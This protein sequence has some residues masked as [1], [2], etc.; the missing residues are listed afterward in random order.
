MAKFTFMGIMA[1][2]LFL[3]LV[4]GSVWSV[5]QTLPGFI[6]PPEAQFVMP[7]YPMPSDMQSQLVSPFYMGEAL[8]S[9]PNSFESLYTRYNLPMGTT[10]QL[11]QPLSYES[12][13]PSQY[14]QG[15]IST[16][17]ESYSQYFDM[18]GRD[19]Y[20]V[21][22]SD[23]RGQTDLGG[24]RYSFAR[25]TRLYQATPVQSEQQQEKTEAGVCTDCVKEKKKSS[26]LR[27]LQLQSVK[28][29]ILSSGEVP[30]NA[31]LKAWDYLEKNLDSIRNRN[32]MTVVDYTKP[33]DQ[34]RLF[35]V[36]L[37][38][39]LVVKHLV[40]HGMNSSGKDK[41]YAVKYSNAEGSK[42]SSHGA[43][44][45]GES[46]YGKYGRSLRLQG[47]IKGVNDKASSRAIVV[48]PWNVNDK[49]RPPVVEETWGCFG[50]A[51]GVAPGLI[52]QMK[53]GGLWYVEP[54]GG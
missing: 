52:E 43:F 54:Y 41:R 35:V 30:K 21:R 33:S 23:L 16:L 32:F 51:P 24:G 15:S 11:L 25:E 53:N 42:Q 7:Q 48:H 28:A 22:G 4:L 5:A 45:T 14:Y 12:I 18:L 19:P 9:P 47:K 13:N 39:G 27:D 46:Y 17:P 50:V 10:F 8:W 29:K 6:L 31:F 37:K 3:V 44:V 34:P 2:G 20:Y 38:N 1:R 49:K 36:N 40:A 26:P